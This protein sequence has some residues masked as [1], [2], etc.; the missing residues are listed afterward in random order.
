V[1]VVEIQDH[2]GLESL[3]VAER[4]VPS[5][6]PGQ[7][8]LR[9]RAAS[10]NYR[11]LLTVKGLYNPKQ[12]LPLIPCSDGVGEV[13]GLGEGAGRFA[14]GDRVAPIFAQRW[15]SGDAT[16]DRLR[17]T[18]GGPLDG[19]LAEEMVVDEEGLVRV[20]E[21]LSDEEAA[22]LPCAAVTAWSAL[23]TN[24]NV[25]A[26]DTVVVLGTGGVAI[27]AL[28]LAV[29][30]GA[31]VI[32][33]SSS[34][35]KLARVKELG[36]WHGINY[37]SE[38]QWGRV[39]RELTA[40]EGADLIVE[41]G[42]AGTL[43]QSLAAVRFG[44]QISLIGNLAGAVCD[45]TLFPIFMRQVRLQGI[46][47]GHRESF[48][49][50]NRAIEVHAIRPVVDRVFPFEQARDALEAM[51]TGGHFGKICVRIAD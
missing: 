26:G 18:L 31:R 1:R 27:F 48:E 50:L 33:T 6:G 7:V 34:D 46:L 12:P 21:H 35:E 9:M 13:V 45:L 43:D 8:R 19:T 38:P 3:A 24:G 25:K 40:G 29:A 44:G 28:Q 14:V 4:P 5:P 36:A 23:V 15:I 47:V 42:G 51:E 20:P 11:D 22:S 16:R 37:R 30:L 49:A 2:F 39:V 10:V 32:V 41:V 17:S